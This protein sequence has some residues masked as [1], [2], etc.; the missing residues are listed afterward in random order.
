MVGSWYPMGSW[1]PVVPGDSKLLVFT[2]AQSC[3]NCR[4][5]VNTTGKTNLVHSFVWCKHRTMKENEKKTGR[6]GLSAHFSSHRW[7][8]SV[9]V[10]PCGSHSLAASRVKWRCAAS[11]R[12]RGGA[13][14]SGVSTQQDAVHI[15][16]FMV[17]MVAV[18]VRR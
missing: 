4:V 8:S 5:P 1:Y 18:F 6:I 3:S 7:F 9:A 15:L 14:D 13:A 12:I 11:R 17:I 2:G 16:E 10:H